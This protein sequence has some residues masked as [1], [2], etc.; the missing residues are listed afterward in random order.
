MIAVAVVHDG[1]LITKAVSKSPFGGQALSTIM[2]K[3]WMK[4]D[5]LN[6]VCTV[7]F[8]N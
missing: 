5:Q 3:V 8:G 6:T 1:F 2:Q 4:W 7:C